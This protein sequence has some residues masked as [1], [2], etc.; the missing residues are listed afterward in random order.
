MDLELLPV[1]IVCVMTEREL[2]VDITQLLVITIV[3][4]VSIQCVFLCVLVVFQ[5]VFLFYLAQDNTFYAACN[6]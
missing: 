2:K 4:S 1:G 5:T 3:I 6:T